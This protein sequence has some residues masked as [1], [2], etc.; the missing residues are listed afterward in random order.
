V[1]KRNVPVTQQAL[2]KPYPG[3]KTEKSECI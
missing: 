2:I 3:R 1:V